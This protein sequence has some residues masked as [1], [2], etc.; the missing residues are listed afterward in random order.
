MKVVEQ[1]AG[2]QAASDEVA[3]AGLR[4]SKVELVP[5]KPEHVAQYHQWM[6]VLSC[7]PLLVSLKLS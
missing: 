1:P 6:Q 3:A 4:G 7:P 2:L 5:Y